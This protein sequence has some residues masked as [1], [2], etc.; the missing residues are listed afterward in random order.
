MK[1]FL[2]IPTNHGWWI[3][4][5]RGNDTIILVIFHFLYFLYT[6]GVQEAYRVHEYDKC[7][8]FYVKW[9]I[10][11]MI[12]NLYEDLMFTEEVVQICGHHEW[13]VRCN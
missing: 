11:I 13:F 5:R 2:K 4:C 9:K 7:T 8:D 10:L 1:I 12:K 6:C 3:V